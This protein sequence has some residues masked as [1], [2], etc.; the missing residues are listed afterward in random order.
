MYI[1]ICVCM[2]VY[3]YIHISIYIYICG[4]YIAPA[5]STMP[6]YSSSL[7]SPNLRFERRSRKWVN[8]CVGLGSG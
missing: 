5:Y 7:T 1:Y 3:I 2:Y 6:W 8:P 4:K